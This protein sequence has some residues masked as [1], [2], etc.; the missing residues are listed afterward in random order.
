MIDAYQLDS[1][2]AEIYTAF[3]QLYT[4]ASLHNDANVFLD[5][6]LAIDPQN[7]DAYQWLAF[8]YWLQEDEEAALA[9][10]NKSLE[11]DPDQVQAQKIKAYL[12]LVKGDYKEVDRIYQNIL[13]RTPDVLT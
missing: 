10:I 5:R 8:N 4:W 13:D 12:K 7:A 6:A 3:G 11:Q 9:Y 2:Q 1:T